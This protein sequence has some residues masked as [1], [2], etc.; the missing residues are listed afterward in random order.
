MTIQRHRLS[1]IGL[2]ALAV[3]LAA[4]ACGGAPATPVS[5]PLPKPS[6]VPAST[7]TPTSMPRSIVFK[8]VT[9]SVQV[10]A[11]SGSAPTSAAAGQ[12]LAPGDLVETG[13]DGQAVMLMD[14][15]TSMVLS[16]NSS[17]QVSQLEGTTLSPV[18]RFLLNLGAVFSIRKGDLPQGASFDVDTPVGTAAIRGS[19]LSVTYLT[20]AGLNVNCLI[21]HCAAEVGGKTADLGAGEM[22]N[23]TQQTG[24]SDVAPMTSQRLHDWANVFQTLADAG[25]P[26]DQAVD[27]SCTCSGF[28]LVCADGT[29]SH[30]FPT[31]AAGP[32][33][34]CDGTTLNCSDG[35]SQDNSPACA[36]GSAT[37][38]CQG[39]HMYCDNGKTFYLAPACTGSQQCACDGPDL[40]CGDTTYRNDPYCAPPD[41]STCSCY[42]G[43]EVCPNGVAFFDPSVC[44]SDLPCSC[45]GTTFVCTSGVTISIPDYPL[46]GGSGQNMG[47]PGLPGGSGTGTGATCVCNG[48]DLYCSDG[49][50]STGDPS[51]AGK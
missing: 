9:G 43:F 12:A 38:S 29:V 36:A 13:A 10:T 11:A 21:G 1:I 16:A 51:C 14:D 25:I 4:A 8:E 24:M 49:T 37:C 41:L 23:A 22:I 44:T 47:L 2:A 45:Q 31:C 32:T 34:S 39:P 18:S 27:P 7:L 46:C 20:D 19:M 3:M 5:T 48:P 6:P 40:K 26:A 33:C 15:G 17:F 35:T 30:G 28:D 42:N 50:I